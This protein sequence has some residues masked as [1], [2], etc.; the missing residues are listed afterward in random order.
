MVISADTRSGVFRLIDADA[1]TA[2]GCGLSTGPGVDFCDAV[3]QVKTWRKPLIPA[4]N[5]IPT[6]ILGISRRAG[7]LED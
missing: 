2:K 5:N 4:M 6:D 7:R 3:R 1:A